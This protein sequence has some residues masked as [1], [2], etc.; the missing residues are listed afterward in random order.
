MLADITRLVRWGSSKAVPSRDKDE[1]DLLTVYT[2]QLRVA[3]AMSFL[4]AEGEDAE[5]TDGKIVDETIRLLEKHQDEPFFIA[6]GLYRPHIPYIAP[7]RYF[8]LYDIYDKPL[9]SLPPDYRDRVPAAALT[10]T[11]EWPNFGTTE[12]E[13]RECIL[14]YDACVT[15]VD[16]QIGRLLAAVD[17]LGLRDNTIIVLWGDHGYH[18]GEHDMWSKVS[19]HKE[20]AQVP[21]IIHVPGKKPAICHSFAELLDL[22]PT[23]SSLCAMKVPGNLQGKNVSALLDNPALKVRDA[24][25]CS[26][27]GML[28]REEKWAYIHYGKSGEL[29]DMKKDP[30]QYNNLI[31]DPKYAKV[32]SVMKEKLKRKL[33]KIQKNDLGE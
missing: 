16:T 4:K 27:K 12:L 17:R 21:L 5:Q 19:V 11:P 24:V 10:S 20:S 18:L 14:A 30:K 3:D 25:L 28:Y 9:P 23:V 7:K 31:N 2:P 13:A 33:S 8:E 29:F 1:E 26:G 15:F 32:L 22:Y 6:A